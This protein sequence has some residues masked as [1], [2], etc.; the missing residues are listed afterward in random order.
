LITNTQ[1]ETKTDRQTDRPRVEGTVEM[2]GISQ[3][4]GRHFGKQGTEG[5]DAVNS[6]QQRAGEVD[7]EAF[8]PEEN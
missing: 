6:E 1:R 3:F 4:E 7:R 8:R 2:A 5:K